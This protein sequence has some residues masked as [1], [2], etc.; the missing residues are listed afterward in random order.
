MSDYQWR[1]NGSVRLCIFV[2]GVTGL[3][4]DLLSRFSRFQCVREYESL[5][6]WDFQ[7]ADAEWAQSQAKF[8]ASDLD[9]LCSAVGG[10]MQV[11]VRKHRVELSMR[12]VNKGRLVA[13][14][15]D[16]L[17]QSAK[18]VAETLPSAAPTFVFTVGDDV[19]DEDMFSAA[20]KWVESPCAPDGSRAVNVLV[21][22][23]ST[24]QSAANFSLASV[25]A[26]QALIVAL[27]EA[28]KITAGDGI[29]AKMST[30]SI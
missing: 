23:H 6:A 7:K 16:T 2:R 18:G 26:V 3:L 15:L 17:Q 20:R 19:T 8:L 30:T 21:G 4:V 14:L 13:S 12:S 5:V 1:V 10:A 11:N 25:T 9:V 27:Y 22:R 28:S 24:P 29:A